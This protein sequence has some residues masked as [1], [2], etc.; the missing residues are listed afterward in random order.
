[1]F[2]ITLIV[3]GVKYGGAF[4][5]S[6]TM[7]GPNSQTFMAMG[8]KWEPAIRAGH[9]W[10]LVTPIF[11]HGG[12]I[13]L[14]SNLFFQL[15][16]GFSMEARWGMYRFIAA[17]FITGIG[18][19]LFSCILS[20]LTVSVGASGALFGLFGYEYSY[21]F[22]NWDAILDN[23][24]EAC[25]LTVILVINL[26]IGFGGPDI[27]N[28]A[29]LGGLLTGIF[30]GLVM[31]QYFARQEKETLIKG[32]GGVLLFGWFLMLILLL[33]VGNPAPGVKY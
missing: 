11:L 32:I 15:R 16:F 14:A 9:V 29:H 23:R 20:P 1:M 19:S 24:M 27:D 18:A 17:Y 28:W 3:G 13:H 4:V 31:S 33:W 2:I 7:L 8:G 30:L 21:L 22:I 5:K 10:L 26:I 12:V 6:N 25:M